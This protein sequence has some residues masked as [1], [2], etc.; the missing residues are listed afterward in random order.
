[1]AVQA[2]LRLAG[3]VTFVGAKSCMKVGA[4]AEIEGGK[5]GRREGGKEGRLSSTIHHPYTVVRI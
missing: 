1:M 4:A 2:S 3:K 5:E